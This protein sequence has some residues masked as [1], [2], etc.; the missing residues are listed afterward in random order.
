MF[1]THQFH[2]IV[3][4]KVHVRKAFQDPLGSCDSFARCVHSI[5]QSDNPTF[6]GLLCHLII[7]S[8]SSVLVSLFPVLRRLT[9]DTN[10]TCSAADFLR[11]Y[12]MSL[13]IVF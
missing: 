11:M 9:W 5:T 6:V 3:S 4:F 8:C 1:G 2:M 10:T 12:F 7:P 13:P